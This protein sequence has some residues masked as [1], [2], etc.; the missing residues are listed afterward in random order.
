VTYPSP[1]AKTPILVA[2]TRDYAGGPGDGRYYVTIWGY[3]PYK[4]LFKQI[5]YN[6]S[7]GNVMEETRIVTAGPLAGYVVVDNANVT[8]RW[9]W[10][11]GILVYKFVDPDYFVR[12]LSFVG[13]A[14]QA[15]GWPDG[16]VIDIETPEILRRLHLKS[17]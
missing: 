7:Y 9:P 14:N 5:F 8:G 16:N 11:F 15:G 4:R 1:K 12:V 6:S 3:D 13:K 17:R 10:P 2:V